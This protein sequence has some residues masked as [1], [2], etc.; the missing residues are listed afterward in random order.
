MILMKVEDETGS[1]SVMMFERAIQKYATEL[2]EDGLIFLTGKVR[3]GGEDSSII[4]DTVCKLNDTPSI[5]W[6]A[7]NDFML[8]H[9]KKQACD[10]MKSNP[11]IGD[12][13]YIVSLSSKA[14]IPLGEISVTEDVI[15]KARIQFGNNNIRIT[16]KAK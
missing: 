9:L 11:G 15:K 6:I 5:L 14:I 4:L 7:T 13:L 1:I 2:I 8:T 16:K 12:Y 10:F 3:G